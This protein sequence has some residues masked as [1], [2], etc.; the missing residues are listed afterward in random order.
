M[1][2]FRHRK[3]SRK[4]QTGSVPKIAMLPRITMFL[5]LDSNAEL[6]LSLL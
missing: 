2:D 1:S 6:Y 4:D 3:W 5:A